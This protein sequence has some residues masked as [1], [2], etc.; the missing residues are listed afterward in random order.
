VLR[1]SLGSNDETAAQSLQRAK[2]AVDNIG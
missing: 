2:T 1:S